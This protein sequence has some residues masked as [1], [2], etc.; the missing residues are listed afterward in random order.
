MLI[1]VPPSETKRPPPDHGRPVD[2]DEL[3]FPGLTP[4]RAQ[5]LE[6]LIATSAAEDA[7]SRLQV[8]P[9]MAADVARNTLLVDLPV[10]PAMDVYTG[11][12]HQGLD[13]GRLTGA[14]A[15]RRDR[16]LVIVSPL[17]GA[18]RSTDRIPSYRLHVCSML[19]GTG[20]L[21]PLWR[22]VLPAVLTDAAGP[23]GAVV[24]LRSPSYQAMGIPTDLWDRTA[25]LRVSYGR[26]GHRI[27][28]VVA[29]RVR[30]E[31]ARHLLASNTATPDPPA[32]ADV[33][34]DRWPVRLEPPERPGRPWTLTLT[35]DVERA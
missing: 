24:D 20:R 22:E 13:A 19:L 33:L 11:P 3:S 26:T 6:A 15:E 7:F 2:L 25:T 35:T 8:R 30:G 17:W 28:D 21:E 34:A 5:V 32:V 18:L 23:V 14:P 16:S 31:A 9:S 4:T 27:G 29:K 10:R 12:L 1:I